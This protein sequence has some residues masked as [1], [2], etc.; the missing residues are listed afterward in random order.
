MKLPTCL[1]LSASLLGA[2]AL[3]AEVIERV[4]ARVNGDIVTL[5]EFEQRQVAALQSARI[6]P[7]GVER[8]LRENNQRI[9]QEAIDELLVV[10]RADEL[11]IKVRAEYIDE[12]LEGIKKDNK[13]ESDE[14]FQEQLRREGLSVDELR[15]NVTRSILKRQVLTRELEP[16][17]AVSDAEVAAEYEKNRAAWQRPASVT[18]REILV[19][20]PDAGAR[21]DE[22]TRR[23][24]E[25]ED[26][27]AL[28]RQHSTSPSAASGGELGRIARGELARNL[29]E[30]AF[31]L[32]EGGVSDPLPSGTGFRILKVEKKTEAGLVPFDDARRELSER[33]RQERLAAEYPKY[34][35]GLRAA[36]V[37]I[38]VMVREVPLDVQLPPGSTLTAPA[39]PA[40]PASPAAPG[41]PLAAAGDEF[42]TT[43]AAQ[44]ERVLPP[45]SEPKDEPT[46]QPTPPPR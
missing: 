41:A 26:F 29:E 18:L 10:Q 30:A 16:K 9:L 32:P 15:R 21:A 17:A 13:I 7:E 6:G 45:G 33:L 36:A 31:A 4:V 25:G 27:A 34:I 37:T 46:P 12:I 35:E 8:F 20:G 38:N 44:P 1:L 28:A 24:R 40:S 43:G 39:A 11:G 19:A 2:A 23:A 22:L 5:S 3:R 42:S 14:Q